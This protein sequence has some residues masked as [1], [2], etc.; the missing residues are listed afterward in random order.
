MEV[1]REGDEQV[2]VAVVGR[3]EGV[4]V[5]APVMAGYDDGQKIVPHQ[6]PGDESPRDAA[7]TVGERVDLRKPVVEPRRHQQGG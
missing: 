5:V 7:V 2:Q 4:N 6:V 3:F 1:R